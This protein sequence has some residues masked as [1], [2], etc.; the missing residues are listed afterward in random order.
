MHPEVW[1]MKI[2]LW[3]K[4]DE[5]RIKM[6][7]PSVGG[8]GVHRPSP[9][10]NASALPKFSATIAHKVN[11][12]FSTMNPVI[13][14]QQTVA[15]LLRADADLQTA[16]VEVFAQDDADILEVLQERLERVERPI[17]GPSWSSP[18]TVWRTSTPALKS[19]GASLRPRSR[20]SIGEHEGFK[21]AL[22]TVRTAVKLLDGAL[23]SLACG[24]EPSCPSCSSCLRV[25][26]AALS[27]RLCGK[28]KPARKGYLTK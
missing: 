28:Q 16:G 15:E 4:T 11:L 9:L 20:R 19:V 7:G 23:A 17:R 27:L 14:L 25:P 10:P 12:F 5:I 6:Q 3:D 18:S 8:V 1:L 13:Q 26:R 24:S 22:D 2:K 21:T